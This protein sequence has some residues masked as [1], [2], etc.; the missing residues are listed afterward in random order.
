MVGRRIGMRLQRPF[1]PEKRVA[2]LTLR[3]RAF[4]IP[5]GARIDFTDVQLQPGMHPSGVTDNP[6]EQGTTPEG[7]PQYRNGTI[8]DGM[9]VV[10]MA[11]IDRPTPVRM[12]VHNA[13]GDTQVGS[14][15]FGTLRGEDA[16][17]DGRQHTATHG[18]G[19]APIITQRSDLYLRTNIEGR[20]HLRLE[21]EDREP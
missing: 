17:V 3:I 4:D 21:W 7:G 9:E 10:A 18:W 1:Y 12:S 13:A 6:R 19:R 14:Y 11:N 2:E 8:H 16:A 5:D 20:A 15:R